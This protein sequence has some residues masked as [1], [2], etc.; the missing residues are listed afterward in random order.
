M[1]KLF[2]SLLTIGVA[3]A[4]VVP[5]A[6]TT[7]AHAVPVTYKIFKFKTDWG[8]GWV[9]NV[10]G[11]EGLPVS[12]VPAQIHYNRDHDFNNR[13]VYRP[14]VSG[15]YSGNQ[16]INLYT[17]LCLQAGDDGAVVQRSCDA[18]EPRQMWHWEIALR[19]EYYSRLHN[20]GKVMTQSS[21]TVPPAGE[22]PS[23][24]LRTIEPGNYD[25]A[26][27]QTFNLADCGTISQDDWT[28]SWSALN[29]PKAC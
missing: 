2:K 22:W 16:L 8:G 17:K 9:L 14:T 11:V 1:R 19:N 20:V 18:T 26:K 23:I 25:V 10:G 7:Q 24:S 3:L 15:S 13:W 4:A 12:G 28:G 21:T 5:A 29:T 6:I 27:R